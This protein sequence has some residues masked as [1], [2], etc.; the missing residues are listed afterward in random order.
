VRLVYR[1]L[2]AEKVVRD[3]KR[4]VR[5]ARSAQ[6]RRFSSS[7]RSFIPVKALRQRSCSV[8]VSVVSLNLVPLH[9]R[10]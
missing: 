1:L 9:V 3:G 2:D 7:F 6:E 5:R 8:G 10:S 4:C